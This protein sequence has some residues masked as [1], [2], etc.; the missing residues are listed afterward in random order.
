MS[1]KIIIF[2]GSGFIGSSLVKKLLEE[3]NKVT[4]ICSNIQKAKGKFLNSNNLE[5]KSFNIFDKIILKD[6]IKEFDVIVNLIGKLFEVK[7]DDFIKYHEI[8]PDILTKNTSEKQHIIHVSA[9]GIEESSKTSKYAKTKLNGENNIIK[10]SNNYNIIKPSIVFGKNDNFFNL[11]SKIANFSP[12]LPL[13]GGGNSKFSPVYVE[14][15]ADSIVTLIK[16]NK[17][18]QNKTFEAYG[19]EEP[20]FKDLMKFI[21]E[22]T[23]KKRLLLKLPFNLAKIQGKLLNSIKIYIITSDQVELLKY[24]N[25]ASKKYD[26]ID[27]LIENIDCYKKIVPKYLKSN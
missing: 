10:N 18:Y 12:F 6:Q 23:N 2:G 5:I 22:V 21:L 27:K 25:I 4:I 13:I 1:K 14:N 19:S 7:K 16:F 8:F 20:T 15:L 26:N 17:K 24:D 11:F 9:L 3:N